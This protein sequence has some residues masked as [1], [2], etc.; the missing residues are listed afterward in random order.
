MG[1]RAPLERPPWSLIV[2][3]DGDPFA[4]RAT[5]SWRMRIRRL[6]GSAALGTL[7]WLA[8][9]STE[10]AAREALEEDGYTDVEIEPGTGDAF[11]W[12]GRKDDSE[13]T[14]TI[15]ISSSPFSTQSQLQAR[16]IHSSVA[17]SNL[18]V[19][20]SPTP[21]AKPA[22]VA[23]NLDEAARLRLS[24]DDGPEVVVSDAADALAAVSA[25]KAVAL[26]DRAWLSARSDLALR[27]E[28]RGDSF[29]VLQLL[30]S[31]PEDITLKLNNHR[32]VADGIRVSNYA[33]TI[34][35]SALELEVAYG[36]NEYRGFHI[37]GPDYRKMATQRIEA[38]EGLT[39]MGS[40][41][42]IGTAEIVTEPRVR[43]G[44]ISV[45]MSLAGAT[46]PEGRLHMSSLH[47]VEHGGETT[48]FVMPPSKHD[49]DGIIH[50]NTPIS[51]PGLGEYRVTVEVTDEHTGKVLKCETVFEVLP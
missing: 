2:W 25:L 4:S 8:G 23:S 39:L 45:R 15:A 21:A 9:C 33:L 26:G 20:P 19:P 27:T 22:P 29:T 51:D 17:E 34:G 47:S 36:S 18:E 10:N 38:V 30:L 50:V 5:L 40:Y 6:I 12:T 31:G 3:F 16:C 35:E 46:D 14:G 44:A 7:V 43:D 42:I 13:C 49:G 24:Y 32:T 1:R 48:E 11:T 41:V 28:L 37:G